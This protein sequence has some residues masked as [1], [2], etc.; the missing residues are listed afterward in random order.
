M[1]DIHTYIVNARLLSKRIRGDKTIYT[2]PSLYSFLCSFTSNNV[3]NSTIFI[4][5]TQVSYSTTNT[6]T[7]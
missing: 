7:L 5:Y 3:Y 4:V 1:I 6:E 2:L